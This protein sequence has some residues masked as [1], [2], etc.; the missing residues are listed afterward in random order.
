MCCCWQI[1]ETLSDVLARYVVRKE[2]DEDRNPRSIRARKARH[3][4]LRPVAECKAIL[5]NC[6][7]GYAR[8]CMTAGI[9]SSF[10]WNHVGE[11]G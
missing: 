4:H 11:H 2:A 3:E 7:V 6:L 1:G 5:I 8:P 10:L 9:I